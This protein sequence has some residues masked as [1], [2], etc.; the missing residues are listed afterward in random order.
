MYRSISG[1][2]VCALALC[3]SA[4][5]Q[6]TT[7]QYALIDLGPTTVAGPGYE[8][9]IKA[10]VGINVP[11]PDTPHASLPLYPSPPAK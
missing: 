11:V 2:L 6:S 4:F 3:S 1:A 7:P 5:A 9:R 10:F 8:P